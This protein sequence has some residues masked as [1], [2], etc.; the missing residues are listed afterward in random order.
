VILPIAAL[1]FFLG[2][3]LHLFLDS[4]TIDGIMPFWPLRKKSSFGLKTG[5]KIETSLFL[6]LV[7]LD[8][9]VIIILFLV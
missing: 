1:G 6:G 5:G 8:V 2:Y 4:F 9:F 3:S 7:I